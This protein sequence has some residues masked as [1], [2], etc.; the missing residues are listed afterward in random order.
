MTSLYVT[1]KLF[2]DKLRNNEISSF[3][4]IFK[5]LKL[6]IRI[7]FLGFLCFCSFTN[8]QKLPHYNNFIAS[9]LHSN[10]SLFRLL[11]SSYRLLQLLL[12]LHIPILKKCAGNFRFLLD[13]LPDQNCSS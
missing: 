4:W 12:R 13:N 2:I 5:L 10:Q 1:K 3:I 11:I 6:T 7:E 9:E 8:N